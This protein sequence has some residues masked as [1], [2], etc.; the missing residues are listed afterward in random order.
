[1]GKNNQQRRAAKRK[2]RAAQ[3]GPPFGARGRQ[4]TRPTE[5]TAPIAP[6][7]PTAGQNADADFL[8]AGFAGRAGVGAAAP[9]AEPDPLVR[10]VELMRAAVTVI[11]DPRALD[12]A[13]RDLVVF[14]G[15]GAA[16]DTHVA[17]LAVGR[18]VL[19]QVG[20]AYEHGW[21]PLDLVHVLRRLA[22]ARA[23]RV[24]AEAVERQAGDTGAALRAPEDWLS[25][26]E[27]VAG[28]R[29]PGVIATAI[30]WNVLQAKSLAGQSIWDAWH[31]VLIVLARLL[32]VAPMSRL[33]PPPSAWPSRRVTRTGPRPESGHDPRKLT[34]IRALLAKAE[35]TEFAAEADAFTEKAQDL[36]TRYSIDEALLADAGDEFE[37]RSRRVHV[38][39][40]Y[41][42]TKA[43]LLATV[44]KVNR[45]KAIWDDRYGIATIVGLP[46]DLD[47]AEMLFTSLLVQA[48]R[49]MTEA[50][51]ASTGGHRLDRA[52]SFRRAFLLSYANRIGERLSVAEEHAQ[53]E[54]SV[55]RGQDLLPVL[56]RKS[57]A[58]ETEF[59]R[60][61]PSTTA[62]RATRVDSRGWQAGRA[63]ADRAVLAK[64]EVGE[65]SA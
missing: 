57:A 37:I 42:Q 14:S 51:A 2:A 35:A 33:G 18:A 24:V 23:A 65:R 38:D 50:G 63:A 64:G 4:A 6:T 46:V 10:A 59:A 32:E 31:D 40:P 41:A 25:Q 39:N 56:V 45:V 60:L 9:G 20:K 61:F 47:L 34:T 62:A 43:Q 21:Q 53:Q 5:S 16:A 15:T 27:E 3:V 36:M 28:H 54:E 58:V 26:V 22:G 19:M 44:G 13:V 49:A 1:M 48:T 52:P 29:L 11:D 55:S 17:E 8:A 30:P 12:D 7:A